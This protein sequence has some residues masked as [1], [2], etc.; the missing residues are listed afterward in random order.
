MATPSNQRH[1]INK[2]T[3]LIK[4][5]VALGLLAFLV[6]KAPGQIERIVTM[7]GA[8]ILGGSKVKDKLGF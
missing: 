7:T 6:V 5:C 3:E 2:A 8:F 4:F 1:L